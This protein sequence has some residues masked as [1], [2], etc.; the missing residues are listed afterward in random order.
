MFNTEEQMKKWAPVLEHADAP[1]FQD[2][3]RKAV[4]AKLLENTEKALREE[5]AQ[6][7][8]LSENNQVAGS[9]DNYDHNHEHLKPP[10]V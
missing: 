1:A 9:I 2:E 3:H 4:T 7:S 5:R 8:F 6:S 10:G